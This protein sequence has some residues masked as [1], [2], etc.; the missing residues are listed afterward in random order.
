MI[1]WPCLLVK[2][3]SWPL[4]VPSRRTPRSSSWMKQPHLSIPVQKSWFK[5][6]WTNSWKAELP[7]SLPIACPLSVMRIWFS[8]WKMEILSSKAT[9]KS[10]WAK[11]DSMPISTIANSQKKWRK[12]KIQ[13]AWNV[14]WKN[15]IEGNSE[16]FYPYFLC[17][18]QEWKRRTLLR[19]RL[20]SDAW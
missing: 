9:T 2:S 7:L 15:R 14:K 13:R 19:I 10:S 4:R 3:N 1:Q 20:I 16:C 5:K 18:K 12:N 11:M 6:P 8:W 17:W